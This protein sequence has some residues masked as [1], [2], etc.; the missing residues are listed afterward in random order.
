M[1]QA[2]LAMQRLQAAVGTAVCLHLMGQAALAM[3]RRL[4]AAGTA[5]G[6][7][8]MALQ[9]TVPARQPQLTVVG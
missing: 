5:I 8:A 9:V 6:E 7:L 3:Q 2:A 1:G 4:A